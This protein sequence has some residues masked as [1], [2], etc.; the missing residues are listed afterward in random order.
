MSYAELGDLEDRF[1]RAL[2]DQELSQAETLLND[3]SFWLGV[4]VPGLGDVVADEP[5]AT[6]AKL[7]VVA[8]VR[9]A[10]LTPGTEG[11]ESESAGVY[12]VKYRNP[13]GNLFLYSR[14]LD[15]IASLLRGNRADAV[16]MRSPGL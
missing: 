16:S 8:M 9:R 3:A 2:T 4:W 10:L 1:P 14:E 15:N 12:S 13:E 6:A 11:A 7:L 5:F